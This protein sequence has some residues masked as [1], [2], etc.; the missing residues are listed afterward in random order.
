MK[1]TK[2]CDC[3]IVHEDV[4]KKVKSKMPEDETL[5]DLSD[6]FKVIGDG[7]RIRILWALDES[8][9]CVCDLANVLNMTKSAIS[10]QLRSLR[11]ANL[12][13]FRKSGKEVFY[14][15]A[16]N[17]VK[18]IFEQGLIHIKEEKK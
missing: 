6:F 12:V 4:I 1:N 7:T 9:M 13:K 16:D 5:S 10:H 3:D 8:E 17:H 18:E 15:L 2:I 14:S 11:E